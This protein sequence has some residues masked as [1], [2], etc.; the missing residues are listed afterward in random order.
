MCVLDSDKVK[1]HNNFIVTTEKKGGQANKRTK[2]YTEKCHKVGTTLLVIG[3]L[4]LSVRACK[5]YTVHHRVHLKGYFA[6]H[7]GTLLYILEICTHTHI[8]K[9]VV[10]AENVTFSL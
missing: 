3:G 9:K 2:R 8:H 7:R 1:K 5:G 10:R 6:S 4:R